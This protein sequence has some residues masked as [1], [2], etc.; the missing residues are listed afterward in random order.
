MSNFVF[1]SYARTLASR[2]RRSSSSA[3]NDGAIWIFRGVNRYLHNGHCNSG[4]KGHEL[5]NGFARLGRAIFGAK[6]G[7][8]GRGFFGRVPIQTSKGVVTSAS[9]DVIVTRLPSGSS[10]ARGA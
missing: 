10:N 4:Y 2:N 7:S 8:S 3:C 9:Q 5:S 6:Q 1:T